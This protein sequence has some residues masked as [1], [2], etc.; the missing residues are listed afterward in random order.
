MDSLKK[1]PM[2]IAVLAKQIPATESLRLD[3]EGRLVRAGLA[4]EMNPYCRR[5][6][7]LGIALARESHGE[8]VVFTLAPAPGEDVLREA[9]AAGAN[10]GILISDPAFAGSDTLATARALTAALRREGPFDLILCGRNSVDADTGQVGPQV[11]EML[12]M[13]FVVSAKEIRLRQHELFAKSERDDGWAMVRVTLPAVLSAAERS[14]APARADESARATV[15]ATAI[16]RLTAAALGSGPWGETGSPTKVGTVKLLET[17]RRQIRLTGS[18]AEQVTTAVRQLLACGGPGVESARLSRKL[19]GGPPGKSGALIGVLLEPRRGRLAQELGT[20]AAVLAKRLGGTAVALAPEGIDAWPFGSWGLDRVVMIRG[21]KVEEDIA[22]GIVYWTSNHRPNVILA[23]G[24][25]YGREVAARTAAALDVGLI[26]DAVE[27]DVSQG[28]VVAWKPAFGGRLLAQ[29]VT[30]SDL[31]MVTLRAGAIRPYLPRSCRIELMN[32]DVAPRGRARVIKR[33]HDDDPDVLFSARAVVG[34]GMGVSFDEYHL[35]APLLDVLN[36]P[37]A[38]S[39][40]V[41]DRGWLP[42]T[43]QVGLT[44][45]HIAPRLYVAVGLRGGLNHA[46]GI[47]QADKVLAINHD[48]AA[49]IFADADIGIT[50]DWREVIPLLAQEIAS[51]HAALG[52]MGRSTGSGACPARV[53]ELMQSR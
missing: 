16:R 30:E 22:R 14:C 38:C 35:L 46:I 32:V 39:R 25:L 23:P 37:L 27:L 20:A 50:G 7:A 19:P 1:E 42:R 31:Q 44:G 15:P 49:P 9:V 28:R 26:G 5:A 41:A 29:I 51:Q 8:C 3:A 33:S 11:A 47:R 17:A 21:A 6:V 53:G 13:P 2:R 45:A 18:A 36:A 34:V 43:R 24:T 48:P 12:D 4:L 10:T 40:K 52:P